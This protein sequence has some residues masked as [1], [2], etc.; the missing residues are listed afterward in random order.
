ML[1]THVKIS[2][3]QIAKQAS[4]SSIPLGRFPSKLKHNPKEHYSCV[5][6]RSGKQLNSPKGTRVEVESKNSHDVSANAL[7]NKDVPQKKNEHEKLK[8]LKP[9]S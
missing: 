2:E 6:L 1:T 8:S 7:P 4:S 9:L 5:L 3:L